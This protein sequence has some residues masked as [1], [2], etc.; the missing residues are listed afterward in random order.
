MAPCTLLVRLS[1]SSFLNSN[2]SSIVQSKFGGGTY[3][4]TVVKVDSPERCPG[5]QASSAPQ[6]FDPERRRSIFPVFDVARGEIISTCSI[7]CRRCSPQHR[8]WHS[9]P[10]HSCAAFWCVASSEV[11]WLLLL[12]DR[13]NALLVNRCM[14]A[15]RCLPS[16]KRLSPNRCSVA[17]E[18]QHSIGSDACDIHFGCGRGRPWRHFVCSEPLALVVDAAAARM[19]F[20]PSSDTPGLAIDFLSG[21]RPEFW[22]MI[23]FPLSSLVVRANAN[24]PVTQRQSSKTLYPNSHRIYRCKVS[25]HE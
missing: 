20:Q 11:P 13:R 15:C 5:S 23:S 12:R 19:W 7:L 1:D 14:M 21:A 22:S 18:R 16:Q 3:D 24:D 4:A 9:L 17:F 2:C 10:H 8:H 6:A 25:A